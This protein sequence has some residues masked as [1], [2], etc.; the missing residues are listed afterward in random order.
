MAC[1]VRLSSL[2]SCHKSLMS[3]STRLTARLSAQANTPQS[4]VIKKPAS[5]SVVTTHCIPCSLD[6][7]TG[8]VVFEDEAQWPFLGLS[9]EMGGLGQGG[10]RSSDRTRI[11]SP[12]RC[13]SRLWLHASLPCL[14]CLLAH[15]NQLWPGIAPI[16]LACIPAA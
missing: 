1:I 10:R 12:A 13:L 9:S 15:S 8:C 4:S 6:P 16:G 7:T 5:C 2:S 14:P 3:D 11:R